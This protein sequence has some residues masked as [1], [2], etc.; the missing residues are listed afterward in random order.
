MIIDATITIGNILEVSVIAAGGLITIVTLKNRILG[1]TD[2]IVDM[3][4]ELKKVGE[5]LI[6]MA[7]TDQRVTNLEK[8]VRDLR[9]GDGF[10]HGPVGIE[11]EYP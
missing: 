5:V 9:R 1:I 3:K 8:D 11:R 6:K 7:I 2:D 4:Q 10:I